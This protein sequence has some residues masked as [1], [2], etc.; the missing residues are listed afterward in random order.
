MGNPR[1]G[2]GR[3]RVTSNLPPTQKSCLQEL[4]TKAAG[5]PFEWFLAD[6][7]KLL[8]FLTEN[9]VVLLRFLM[10]LI[11]E[12]AGP[13]RI[14][15]YLDE[16]VPGNVLTPDNKRWRLKYGPHRDLLSPHCAYTHNVVLHGQHDLRVRFPWWHVCKQGF[17][18]SI[19]RL[20]M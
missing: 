17:E 1:G 7:I 19:A 8:K 9:C 12:H 10:M 4:P 16:I 14:I 2:A 5:E 13:L 6:P 18:C 15:L 11:V 20:S 3:Q